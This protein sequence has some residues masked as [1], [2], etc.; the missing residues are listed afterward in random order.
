[1]KQRGPRLRDGEEPIFKLGTIFR[2]VTLPNIHGLFF[3]GGEILRAQAVVCADLAGQMAVEHVH[4]PVQA[5]QHGLGFAVTQAGFFVTGH[6]LAADHGGEGNVDAIRADQ[7][8]HGLGH[9]V[10]EGGGAILNFPRHLV[11]WQAVGFQKPAGELFHVAQAQVLLRAIFAHAGRAHAETEHQTGGHVAGHEQPEINHL[12]N[13]RI[14]HAEITAHVVELYLF[15]EAQAFAGAM[16]LGQMLPGFGRAVVQQR[17]L[18]GR[19]LGLFFELGINV[20]NG[21]A[22]RA[23]I[24]I[25]LFPGRAI[26]QDF[27]TLDD[28]DLAFMI[29]AGL[30]LAVKAAD[31]LVAGIAAFE[32]ALAGGHEVQKGGGQA[33]L[34]QLPLGPGLGP[35]HQNEPVAGRHPGIV[36]AAKG[37]QSA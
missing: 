31:G 21:P 33:P 11:R 19:V 30:P 20:V 35:V 36:L 37:V 5:F 2:A 25:P 24:H 4:Q 32:G 6:G 28:L 13:V 23:Q 14:H 26:G 3:A 22:I 34:A 12:A 7:L 17:F 29:A 15:Q 16:N 9:G 27:V 10:A 18:R 8:G 1:M